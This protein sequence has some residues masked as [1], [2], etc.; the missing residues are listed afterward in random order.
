MKESRENFVELKGFTTT[1]GLEEMIEFAYTGIL[2]ITLDTID[3]LLN[4][5]SHLQ[6]N[7]ALDLINDFL[8]KNCT[9][10]N[11]V[12]LLK[13]ADRFSL[14]EVES[15]INDY[16]A[17]NFIDIYE[18]EFEQFLELSKDQIIQQL[19]NSNLQICSESDLF[20]I[21]CKWIDAD[22]SKRL[23]YATE[24]LK[25]IRFMTMSSYELADLVESIDFM[26]AIPECYQYL[27]DAY[28]YHALPLRQPIIFN[29]Q[30]K[31]RNKSTLVAVGENN[32]FVLNETK[33]KW[34]TICQA[35]L[36]ENYRKIVFFIS[37]FL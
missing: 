20:L 2:K 6:I 17:R 18:N 29:D 3:V 30:A 27:V 5:A 9:L 25:N 28:R 13:I 34:E 4:A 8:I 12:N 1:T 21:V 15:N 37:K 7:D 22:R 23:E 31:L 10:K 16:M 11:C 14:N 33:Q 32:L 26:K 19:N 24:I 35:P 36:E